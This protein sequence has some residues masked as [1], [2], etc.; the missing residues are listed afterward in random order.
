MTTTTRKSP[1]KFGAIFQWQSLK[2]R[3]T[4]ST[5]AIFLTGIWSLAFFSSYTLQNDMERTLGE[6]QF[7]TVSVVASDI[8]DELAERLKTLELIAAKITPTILGNA[9]STQKL[10]E[11]QVSIKGLFNY[12]ATVMRLDGIVI[13]DVPISA[14]RL[15]VNYGDREWVVEAFRKEKSLI[16]KPAMGKKS[17]APVFVMVAPIQDTHGKTIGAVLGV[18][19]LSKPSFLS[20]ITDNSYGKTGGYLLVAPKIRTIVFATDK[21]RIME[22]LTGTGTSSLIERFIQ[23]YEGSGVTINSKG[24]EVLASAKGIPVS[25]WY[26]AAM[27][28]TK[29]A[30]AP[31]RAMQQ[32]ML[33]AAIFL[34]LLAGGLTWWMLKRQ[35]APVFTTIKTLA[36]LSDTDQPPQPLTIT[37]QDEIGELIGGFNHLLKTM[38]QREEALQESEEKFSKAFQTSPYAITI[39]R[40]ED[41]TFIEVNDAFTSMTGFTRAEVIAGSSIGLKMWVNEE[42]RRSVVAALSKGQAV[43]G[44]A[45]PFRTKSGKVITGLF[46]AQVIHLSQGHCILSSIN[47]ITERKKAEAEIQ[48]LNAELEQRVIE[49]TAQLEAANKDLEAFSYSV[50][51]DLRAP[52]RHID[53]YVELLVSRCREGLSD[54]GLHYV[55]TIADSARQMGVLIDNLLQFSRTGRTEMRRETLDMNKPLQEALSSLKEVHAERTIEWVIGELPDVHGDYAMLRQVWKNLLDNAVKYTRTREI[56]IIEVGAREENGEILFFIRDNG[57]GFDMRHAGKLFGVFQRLHPLEEFEGTGIG[58]ANVH[59]IITRHG[60]RI[61]VEAVLNQGAT[62]YFTLPK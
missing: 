18:T 61:W 23:G 1:T 43:V 49:R 62:F 37:R 26:I 20:K 12:G 33:L 51:H 45:Y 16:G 5:L 30:F 25:G 55:E 29:E 40:P 8:N 14:G 46:S 19:D 58:L 17:N 27:M 31:L 32:R 47:D 35:L 42:D 24:E 48:Q 10:L 41:G 57:V 36:T 53:G 52:L 38:A 60:G 56:T 9:A 7:S 13:A 22:V 2:T 3:V 15:G 6:Q 50:S 28:P 39:T 44:K 34:T 59:R 54:K 21:K 11:S 4:V